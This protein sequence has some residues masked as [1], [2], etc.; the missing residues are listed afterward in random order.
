MLAVPM[1]F[2]HSV[3]S[4][5]DHEGATVSFSAIFMRFELASLVVGL[6]LDLREHTASIV[7]FSNF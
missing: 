5:L 1:P 7:A 4:F 6:N 2:K 3:L